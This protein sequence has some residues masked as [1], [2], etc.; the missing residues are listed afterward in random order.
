MNDPTTE[1]IAAIEARIQRDTEFV[2]DVCAMD[3]YKHDTKEPTG[4]DA[5][6]PADLIKAH[7]E[8]RLTKT[9]YRNAQVHNV[10]LPERKSCNAST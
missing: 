3:E 2:R 9:G 1:D 5:G 7:L 6:P 8:G 10:S 4:L